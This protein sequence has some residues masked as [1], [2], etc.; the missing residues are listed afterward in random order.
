MPKLTSPT[1]AGTVHGK[2]VTQ[3]SVVLVIA[4]IQRSACTCNVNTYSILLIHFFCPAAVPGIL[5]SHGPLL[6]DVEPEWPENVQGES[7]LAISQAHYRRW[8][9]PGYHKC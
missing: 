3:S 5:P 9:L 1:Q 6:P 2:S 7:A 8:R 4:V